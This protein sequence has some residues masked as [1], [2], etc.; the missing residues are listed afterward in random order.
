MVQRL[1]LAADL[2]VLAHRGAA[3]GDSGGEQLPAFEE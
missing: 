3:D 2:Q 1:A